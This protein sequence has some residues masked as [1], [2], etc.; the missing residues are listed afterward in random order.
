MLT[1]VA[2]SVGHCC[3][4][5]YLRSIA[6]PLLACW[7]ATGG[8]VTDL[9]VI[10]PLLKLPH[11]RNMHAHITAP[12]GDENTNMHGSISANASTLGAASA[13]DLFA[14]EAWKAADTLTPSILTR[15]GGG[16]GA[17]ED[18]VERASV[19]PPGAGGQNSLQGVLR[20]DREVF[21]ATGGGVDVGVG[22]GR[23]PCELH[24]TRVQGTLPIEDICGGNEGL[25]D[26]VRKAQEVCT[27]LLI[28]LLPCS[29]PKD[30]HRHGWAITIH[31]LVSTLNIRCKLSELRQ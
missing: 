14:H 2:T 22:C 29:S 18:P 10:C 26:T 12:C 30:F 21:A 27:Y 23:L 13:C 20:D 6:R 16:L 24:V 31:F 15:S 9:S 19:H 11:H 1:W 8:S 7:V 4:P 25:L 17:A 3:W 5:A 28:A